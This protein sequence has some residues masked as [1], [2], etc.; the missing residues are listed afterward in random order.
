[1]SVFVKESIG[2]LLNFYWRTRKGLRM[3]LIH[4][5]ITYF[6]VLGLILVRWV[7]APDLEK[8]NYWKRLKKFNADLLRLKRLKSVFLKTDYPWPWVLWIRLTYIWI[9][10]ISLEA[11]A[12]I[13]EST[14]WLSMIIVDIIRNL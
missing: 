3:W 14:A 1:M 11:R 10:E 2:K 6:L 9:R 7:P 12:K 4:Y 5:Y 8:K 13:L